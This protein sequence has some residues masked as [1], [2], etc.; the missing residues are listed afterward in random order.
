MDISQIVTQRSD[1]IRIHFIRYV[2]NPSWY[3]VINY[4]DKRAFDFI[5]RTL[6]LPPY[7]ESGYMSLDI[8]WGFALDYEDADGDKFCN[9]LKA[10]VA[11]YVLDKNPHVN[12]WISG[13]GWYEFKDVSNPDK[14]LTEYYSC[15][16]E[17]KAS[18]ST[19]QATL[20]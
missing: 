14:W 12:N 20:F 1:K 2:E 11:Q 8:E 9:F 18:A 15:K 3:F 6:H 7:E 4:S 5:V 16:P 19:I 13:H 10:H 17:N